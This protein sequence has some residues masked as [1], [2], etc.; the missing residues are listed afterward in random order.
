M[1]EEAKNDKRNGEQPLESPMSLLTSRQLQI[2]PSPV[3]IPVS[4][5]EEEMW[6]EEVDEQLEEKRRWL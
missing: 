4:A 1:K 5:I 6:R 2:I 3:R